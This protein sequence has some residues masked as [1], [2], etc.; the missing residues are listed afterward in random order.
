[1]SPIQPMGT[2]QVSVL[3]MITLYAGSSA[4]DDDWMICDGSAIDR[5]SYAPLFSLIG[6]TYGAGDGVSTF[7]IPDLRGRCALGTGTGLTAE[8]G[9]TGTS[10]SLG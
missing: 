9:S 5:L 2:T 3:G 10:R 8:G 1:M 7:N 6:T 4:P